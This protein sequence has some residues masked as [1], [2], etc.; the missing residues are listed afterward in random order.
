MRFK[1]VSVVQ[2]HVLPVVLLHTERAQRLCRSEG[3]G[4]GGDGSQGVRRADEVRPRPQNR[5]EAR[6]YTDTFTLPRSL[7]IIEQKSHMRF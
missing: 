1:G 3:G 4:G 6:E 7:H 5:E 2:V